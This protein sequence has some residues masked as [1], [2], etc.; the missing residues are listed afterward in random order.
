MSRREMMAEYIST[1]NITKMFPGVKA[2]DNASLTFNSGMVY[3]I[4]GENGA[5]KSTFAKI[6][7]GI[8]KADIGKIFIKGKEVVDYNATEALDK[9]KIAV[10]HQDETLFPEM[11][12]AENFFIEVMDRFYK[13]GFISYRE[14]KKTAE[15]SLKDLNI[16][17]DVNK[18]VKYLRSDE[19]KMLEFARAIYYQPDFLILDEVTAPLP[20]D[21]I[22]AVFTWVKE[23]RDKTKVVLYISHKLREV[24]ELSDEI[25]VFKDGKVAGKVH[26][27]RVKM[28]D[29]IQMMVGE[30][31]FKAVFPEKARTIGK[32][33]FKV[34]NLKGKGIDMEFENREGEI[35]ALAGLAG[36]GMKEALR[37]IYGV[38][39][40]S[41]DFYLDNKKIKIR[42]VKD[43]SAHG[44][45]YVSDEKEAEE[46]FLNQSVKEN[47]IIPSIDK[48][49]NKLGILKEST[50]DKFAQFI[51]S[52]FNIKTPSLNTLT[53]SLSGGN[54]QKVVVGRCL[55]KNIRV[56]LA[57]N[58]T[59]GLDIASKTEIYNILRDLAKKGIAVTVYLSEL[60]E[61]VNFPD[62]V[63]IMYNGKIVDELKGDE[64]TE[65]NILKAYFKKVSE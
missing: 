35:L 46:L 59:V 51:V 23:L 57:S 9:Y 25:V 10:V 13:K 44:I 41:G 2:L 7:S 65:E 26:G 38:M 64:I 43:A 60:P 22:E 4:V 50:V 5:G 40:K 37:M 21:K 14:L 11:S 47:I 12:V 1:K 29:L 27:S 17:V 3:S 28:D 39:P 16:N 19:R 63:L 31:S 8:Y 30:K 55:L 58:P 53:Q 36:H 34:K 20:E 15:K 54:K 6:L 49:A 48:T 18:K 45:V 56:L 42:S 61:I 62:R 33:I 24:L 32:T 52:R